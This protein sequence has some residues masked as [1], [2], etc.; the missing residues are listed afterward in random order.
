MIPD[1]IWKKVIQY[2]GT[3]VLKT[4]DEYSKYGITKKSYPNI[5]IDNLTELKA[6]QI[7]TKDFW[8]KLPKSK[9]TWEYFSSYINTGTPMNTYD[10]INHYILIINNK[11]E[12]REYLNG[13]MNRSCDCNK[14][15]KNSIDLRKESTETLQFLFQEP[16]NTTTIYGTYE[17]LSLI[18]LLL[19]K[20]LLHAYS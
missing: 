7:Y 17:S 9:Q 18:G 3:K 11:P 10:L 1:S 8:N 12:K 20:G 16:V 5:D 14:Y 4:K 2:E 13:W 19:Y 15:G 6:K